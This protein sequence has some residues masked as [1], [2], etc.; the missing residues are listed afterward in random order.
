MVMGINEELAS[1]P[2][3]QKVI[4]KWNNRNMVIFEI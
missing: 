2:L 4:V 3:D 1:Q